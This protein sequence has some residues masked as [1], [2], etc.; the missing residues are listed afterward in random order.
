[1]RVKINRNVCTSHLAFCERCLGRFLQHPEGY[2]RHCFEVLEDDGSD[3][4]TIDL[5]SGAYQTTLRLNKAQRELL[6]REG[7]D[8]FVSFPVPIYRDQ[9]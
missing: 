1:M 3:I 7:W 8:H 4:L 9:D 2:E 6:A 5:T